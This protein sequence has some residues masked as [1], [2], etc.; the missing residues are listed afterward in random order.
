MKSFAFLVLAYNHELFIIDHLESIK[1]QILTYGK[2]LEIDLIIN[3]DCHIKFSVS[4][5]KIPNKSKNTIIII[6]FCIRISFH[7]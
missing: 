2:G 5:N 7:Q 1:F 6:N 4:F 3:D